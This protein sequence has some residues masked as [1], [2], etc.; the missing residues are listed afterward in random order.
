MQAQP[1]SYLCSQ[2]LSQ[3]DDIL[4]V[5]IA[6]A[7]ASSDEGNERGAVEGEGRGEADHKFSL[8]LFR[9][10]SHQLTKTKN[11]NAEN[12]TIKCSSP[13]SIVSF[14]RRNMKSEIKANAKNASIIL[15][16]FFKDSA[17]LTGPGH[18]E[19]AEA[20]MPKNMIAMKK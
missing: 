7:I 9:R 19:T 15:N 1:S 14:S 17:K 13:L 3:G 5:T 6:G 12:A 10:R 18:P 4:F 16:A 11:I 2:S 20:T 8:C